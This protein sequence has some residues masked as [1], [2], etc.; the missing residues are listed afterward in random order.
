MKRL[1]ARVSFRLIIIFP[2]L[3]STCF[4]EGEFDPEINLS[5]D[6][7]VKQ[8]R[9]TL[10]NGSGSFDFGLVIADGNDQFFSEYISFR[11]ENNGIRD[12]TLSSIG[13]VAGDTADF[14]LTDTASSPVEPDGYTSFIVRFDP[15]TSGSKTAT[16]EVANND[17][18]EAS[19]TFSV[20][21][22]TSQLITPLGGAPGDTFG[23]AVGS[24]GSITA[25]G[26]P[27][28]DGTAADAGA[29]TKLLLEGHYFHR[30][31]TLLAD[32]GNTS[33]ALGTALAVSPGGSIAA[34]APK[35][36]NDT[37]ITTGAVYIYTSG[38]TGQYQDEKLTP[39]DGKE[40]DC[41]GS[42][43]ALSDSLLLVGSPFNDTAGAVYVY[44]YNGINWEFLEK[45]IPPDTVSDTK[46]GSSLA[47][48]GNDVLIG[49]PLD[50]ENGDGSGAVY[51]YTFDGYNLVPG[52]KL[53]AGDGAAGDQFGTSVS[54]SPTYAFVGAPDHENKGAGYIYDFDGMNYTFV[55]KKTDSTGV[56]GDDF[57]FSGAVTSNLL[58]IG[59]RNKAGNGTCSGEAFFYYFDGALWQ[60]HLMLSPPDINANDLFGYAVA[61]SGEFGFVGAPG[62]ET[63]DGDTGTV[64]VFRF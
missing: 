43:V 49:A 54:L 14:D 8:G 53:T 26:I 1:R 10:A 3:L 22:S 30:E 4:Q 35:A 15:L 17:P 64:Y 44:H 5:P 2:L 7:T 29:V 37:G 24:S 60:Y 42:S 48:E 51:S 28:H 36:A 9:T 16:V 27:S 61:L 39:G 20:N 45:V 63:F 56:D 31:V 52:E 57:G 33:H 59:A 6:I 32:D 23:H 47:L 62:K 40:N 34:G 13:I 12:L 25:V 41:F 18:D 38:S 55:E 46:F 19:Y 58:I 21:G 50:A 11:I